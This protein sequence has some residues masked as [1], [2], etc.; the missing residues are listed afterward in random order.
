MK[1]S[2]GTN[3]PPSVRY[4]VPLLGT[5][6][7]DKERI[8][9]NGINIWGFNGNNKGQPRDDT[10]KALWLNKSLQR[11][12]VNGQGHVTEDKPVTCIIC[13]CTH[14][15]PLCS[16]QILVDGVIHKKV[17]LQIHQYLCNHTTYECFVMFLYEMQESIF[18]ITLSF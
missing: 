10:C 17:L 11:G 3:V 5:V 7:S 1:G 14:T 15:R 18:K 16:V 4:K 6:L 9:G 12:R 8:R 13:I 2:T